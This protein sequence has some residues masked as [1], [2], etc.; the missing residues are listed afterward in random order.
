MNTTNFDKVVK[1]FIENKECEIK[2]KTIGQNF[3]YILET[4]Q[5]YFSKIQKFDIRTVIVHYFLKYMRL[6]P[7]DLKFDIVYEN[8]IKYLTVITGEVMNF[9]PAKDFDLSTKNLTLIHVIVA[10]L[11]MHN[12]PNNK[13]NWGYIDDDKPI[14]VDF[15]L[16]PPNIIRSI[17]KEICKFKHIDF[18]KPDFLLNRQQFLKDVLIPVTIEMD[19]WLNKNRSSFSCYNKNDDF[20]EYDQVCYLVNEYLQNVR[21]RTITYFETD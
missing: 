18:D 10:L 20:C 8:N 12:I 7:T 15:S 14:I 6:G 21:K 19:M 13:D 3:G 5:R 17:S 16:Q 2:P 1:N 4:K 11:E 9:K